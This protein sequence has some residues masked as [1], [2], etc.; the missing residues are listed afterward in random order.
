[1]EIRRN[2]KRTKKDNY[3]LRCEG[4]NIGLPLCI[5]GCILYNFWLQCMH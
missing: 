2:E 5:D 4:R 1:M 3:D